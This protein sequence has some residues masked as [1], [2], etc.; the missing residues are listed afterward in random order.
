MLPRRAG[1]LT[2]SGASTYTGATTINGGTVSVDS[3]ANG[4][5]T[6]NIGQSTNAAANF[7]NGGT[8]QFPGNTNNSTD[9]LFTLGAGGGTISTTGTGTLTFSN[10]ARD[11][12]CGRG[13]TAR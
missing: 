10:T 2:L 3:L 6:S 8:L 9:R 5:A 11:R 7:L 13:G 4:G 12:V 1:T